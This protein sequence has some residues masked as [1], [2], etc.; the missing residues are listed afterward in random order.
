MFIISMAQYSIY[1]LIQF[2]IL[3]DI[4]WIEG[5]QKTRE[6][7]KFDCPEDE[8]TLNFVQ[9]YSTMWVIKILTFLLKWLVFGLVVPLLGFDGKREFDVSQEVV[10]FLAF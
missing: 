3:R 10:W 7:S 6:N 1:I 8:M 5:N 2:T 4:S 9:T